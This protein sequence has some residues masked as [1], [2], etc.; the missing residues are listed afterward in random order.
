MKFS[1]KE[2][3]GLVDNNLDLNK[4]KLLFA[5][6]FGVILSIVL[7]L[8]AFSAVASIN[9]LMTSDPNILKISQFMIILNGLPLLIFLLFPLSIFINMPVLYLSAFLMK[10]TGRGQ[11]SM[12]IFAFV[13]GAL[14]GVILN[15]IYQT[16]IWYALAYALTCMWSASFYSLYSKSITFKN[17]E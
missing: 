16:T 12:W 8:A 17:K 4:K 15:V 11:F 7:I 3:F 14:S 10:L 9:I 13:L 5:S 6:I 1:F 2:R